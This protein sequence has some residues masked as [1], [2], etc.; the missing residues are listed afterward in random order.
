MN[1]FI[2]GSSRCGKS[3]LARAVRRT[4]DAQAV[5]G[6][7]F[8]D[9][10]RKSTEPG[11]IPILHQPRAE[12]TA[13]EQ[14]FIDYHTLRTDEEIVKKREQASLVWSFL[15]NYLVTINRESH[16]NVVVESIDVWPDLIAINGLRH[17]AVFMVDTSMQQW[18]RIAATR[19]KDNGDWMHANNYSDARI[20]AWSAF[21]VRRSEMIKGLCQEHDYPYVDLAEVGFEEGQQLALKELLTQPLRNDLPA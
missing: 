21:N 4:A 7:A 10:L 11:T 2:G 14:E 16:D 6:D 19:G 12:K 17:R 13:D 3:T 1:Y 18:E 8:R 5:S 15:A 20:E 9:A